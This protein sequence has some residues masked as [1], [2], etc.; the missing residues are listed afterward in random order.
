MSFASHEADMSSN[1]TYPN[2]TWTKEDSRTYAVEL[3]G[4]RVDLRYEASGFQSGWAV[5]AG[6]EL[7]ERCSELMQARGLA[8]AIASK[9]L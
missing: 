7:V 5:Y 9:G 6:D 1:P 2:A 8:L 3:D 4:R